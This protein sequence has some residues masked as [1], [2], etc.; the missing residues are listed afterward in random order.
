MTNTAKRYAF[1]LAECNQGQNDSVSS[2]TPTHTE[3]TSPVVIVWRRGDKIS[4]CTGDASNTSSPDISFNVDQTKA[5]RFDGT[6]AAFKFLHSKVTNRT[7]LKGMID[8]GA[9]RVWTHETLTARQSAQRGIMAGLLGD[10]TGAQSAPC[11]AILK[12]G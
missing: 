1:Y 3:A 9:F 12:A 2:H 6:K 4:V 7:W 11:G 10:T 5:R 8:S